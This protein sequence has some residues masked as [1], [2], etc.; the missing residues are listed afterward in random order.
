MIDIHSHI[1]PAVDDGSAD[2]D[3]SLIM[4]ETAVRQGITDIVLTPHYRADYLTNRGEIEQKFQ[5]LKEAA[6]LKGINVALY[7]GQEIYCFEGMARA[8]KEGKLLTMNG[9][10]YVLVE[11]S[12]K[13]VMDI[14]ETVYMLKNNGYIPI[15]AHIGRYFYSDVETAREVKEI[16]GLIQINASTI[17]KTLF[18]KKKVFAMIKE[19]L[20]DFVASDTHFKRVNYFTKA[21]KKVKRKFG[22]ET[23]NKLFNENAK[24]IIGKK[25]QIRG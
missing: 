24:I 20:V 8:L 21:Y 1:L 6:A 2:I 25:K 19:G 4:L 12:T 23:A 11:F 17:C 13:H 15:V 7:L 14:A 22:E 9:T 3:K 18:Q 16:G 10:K 5:E